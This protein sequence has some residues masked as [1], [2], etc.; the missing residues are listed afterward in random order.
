VPGE[1]RVDVGA[2][3]SGLEQHDRGPGVAHRAHGHAL[4]IHPR[5]PRARRGIL[6]LVAD[7]H[8]EL[9]D[10]LAESLGD[11]LGRHAL[12]L[13]HVVEVRRA[14][15]RAR[16]TRIDR[17]PRDVGDV[18]DVRSDAVA[19]DVAAVGALREAQRLPRLLGEQRVRHEHGR[20][21]MPCRRRSHL[22]RRVLPGPVRRCN[23]SASGGGRTTDVR[24]LLHRATSVSWNGRRRGGEDAETGRS[25]R[26]RAA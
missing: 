25:G 13:D 12:V 23:R 11:L 10:L 9:G 22:R 4:L 15:D 6:R 18:T 8:H 21:D 2:E 1:Q 5:A 17:E 7:R 16:G 26:C 3:V 24:K 19:L 14:D 20:L